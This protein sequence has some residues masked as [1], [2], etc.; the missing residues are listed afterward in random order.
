MGL[1]TR[2]FARPE[3]LFEEARSVAEQIAGYPPQTVYGIKQT[4]ERT[5]DASIGV[6]MHQA[7]VWNA[8]FLPS[9]DFADLLKAALRGDR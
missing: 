3:A 1:V 2:V 9:P 7:A 6:G 4:L 8:A 5:Q